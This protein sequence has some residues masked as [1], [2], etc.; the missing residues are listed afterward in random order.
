MARIICENKEFI[1]LDGADLR[2]ILEDELDVAFGCSSGYCGICQIEVLE[3]K[4]NLNEPTEPEQELGMSDGD[5]RLGCQC[6][7]KSGNVKLRV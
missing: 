7:I 6:K 4:E 1:L 2:P 3:G 5:T